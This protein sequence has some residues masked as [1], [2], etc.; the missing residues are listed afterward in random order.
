MSCKAVLILRNNWALGDTICLSALMRDIHLEYPGEYQLRMIGNYKSFWNNHPYA[1][2]Q[3]VG[4]H[5]RLVALEYLEGIRAAGRGNKI[6]FLSWFHRSF[7]KATGIHVPVRL[8]KGHI[9]LSESDKQPKIP[10]RYWIVNAG[11]KIDMTAKGWHFHRYQT[12]VDALAAYGIRCVQMGADFSKHFHPKLKN[13]EQAVGTT[14]DIKDLFSLIYNAEGVICGVTAAMH[15]AAAFD[16][17]CVV[18]AGGREEPWWEAYTN[19]APSTFG[20]ECLPVKIPHRFL[21]TVGLLDCGIGNTTKGCW[22]DRTVPIEQA[23]YTNAK[24]KARLCLF[25]VRSKQP[26]PRCMDLITPDMVVEAVLSY[27]VDGTL[28]PP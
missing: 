1:R 8:P 26:V 25:P 5:G 20:P 4:E 18:V 7:E 14:R 23:D 6:H 9:A 17:P 11:F 27:Y 12:V 13:C 24:N 15:I 10:G 16:K 22:R 21:H 3:G 19:T 28:P 2:V